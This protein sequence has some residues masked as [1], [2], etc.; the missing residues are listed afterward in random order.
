VTAV[1]GSGPSEGGPPAGGRRDNLDNLPAD[2]TRFIGRRREL[3]AITDA[4][5]SHR[6]VTLRGTAGVGKTRLALRAAA[7]ARDSFADGCWLAEL[8]ALR[9]PGLL[10]RTVSAALGLPDEAAGD[11]LELLA[12]HLAGQETL[13]V[14]DTCEHI[15]GAC[16]DLVTALLAAAPGLRILVTSRE[17]LGIPAEHTLTIAPLELP[18]RPAAD[19]GYQVG[20]YDAI[21]LF[22]DRAQSAMPEFA[23]TPRNAG[24]V[25]ELC[26]R[27]D[28]IPLALE[29]AAVRLRSMAP[30]EI[31]GRLDSGFAILGTARTNVGR[32]RT[33][34]AAV[35]WSY[36]L[37]TPDEQ[38]LWARLSVFP[39]SFDAA[40][41]EHVCGA[42][43]R[44]RLARLAEK[45]IVQYDEAAGRYRLLDTMR[46]F[47]AE[48]LAGD[49][50]GGDGDDLRA[51]HLEYYHGLVERAAAETLS[52]AQVSW[53]KRLQ[54]E[55]DNLRAALGW[56][57]STPDHAAAGLR[58]TVL[59]RTYWLMTGM[60]TEG[61][62]WHDQ[63]VAVAP[64]TA[65]NAWAVYGA[66]ILAVQQ[67]D[68]AEAAPALARAARLAAGLGDSDLAA[69]VTDAE[70]IVAFYG[71]DLPTAAARHESAL[72]WQEQAGFSDAFA[73]SSY[74]RLASV[75]LLN[76]DI[77]RATQLCE[78]YLRRCDEVGE[79][80]GRG[81]ALWVRGGARWLSGDN[82][83]AVADALA[84]LAIKAALGDLHTVTMAFDLLAVCAAALADYERAAVLYGA[85]DKFWKILNAPIQMGPGYAAIRRSA[86]DTARERLGEERYAAAY[87][88]G[89]AL[90]LADAI[91]VARG[92]RPALPDGG[93]PARP[94]T[95]RER[96]IAGLVAAGL[97]NRDIAERLYLS[98]RTVDSHLEH[99]FGKLGFASRTQLTQWVRQ[100]PE[101]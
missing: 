88:R 86:G 59:L 60:F 78:E 53:M 74:G 76:M 55:T 50:E 51:R 80:W 10:P 89:L 44:E 71:D 33:L 23:L 87:S 84:S 43:T 64:G 2:V 90:T 4:I 68:L 47:G 95:R 29:L 61:R 63:A 36:E 56:S 11:P 19:G 32:H 41:A 22:A 67:G 101:N 25:A 81:T 73:L 38:A 52:P 16:A 75:C 26:R 14:L 58:M 82:E 7:L 92:E 62:R 18:G 42:G 1:P 65:D 85:G 9:D 94:L 46:E 5:A 34:H 40:A 27:L 15:A 69:H 21:A 45:S 77:A 66:A 20:D 35:G 72:A 83:A 13:L 3:P 99:I 49:R 48:Q 57:L 30:E 37:C 96:Q 39:G 98:K 8:S 97:G 91:A 79:Q 28:G 17:P 100:Q 24:V 93:Q 54:Q 31:L 70:G 6:L 12:E